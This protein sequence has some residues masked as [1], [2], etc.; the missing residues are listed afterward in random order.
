MN[1]RARIIRDKKNVP[2]FFCQD[3][4]AKIILN[5]LKTINRIHAKI[6][7]SISYNRNQMIFMHNRALEHFTEICSFI[8]NIMEKGASATYS[9]IHCNPWIFILFDNKLQILRLMF[10]TEVTTYFNCSISQSEVF[11]YYIDLVNCS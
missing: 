2:L 9:S 1:V 10:P 4:K 8:N 6:N 11:I 3:S 7:S 5:F